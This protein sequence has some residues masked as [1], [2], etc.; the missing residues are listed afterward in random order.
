VLR[1][2]DDL[3]ERG[4]HLVVRGSR[5]DLSEADAV[6]EVASESGEGASAPVE[7]ERGDAVGPELEAPLEGGDR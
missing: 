3:R 6:A 4:E 7:T 1:E 2:L 5:R